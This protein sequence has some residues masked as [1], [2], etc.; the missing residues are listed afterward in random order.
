M[1]LK[2][3][4]VYI[5]LYW[6]YCIE[7]EDLNVKLGFFIIFGRIYDGFGKGVFYINYIY[8]KYLLNFFI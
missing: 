1:F 6:I 3:L 7:E 5:L 2:I 8:V 4:K